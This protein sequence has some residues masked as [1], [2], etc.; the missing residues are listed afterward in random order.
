MQ[1]AHTPVEKCE[2]ARCKACIKT[3]FVPFQEFSR[4]GSLRR[5]R[6]VDPTTMDVH[7]VT[8]DE[9]VSV[10]NRSTGRKI[11]GAKAPP[12]KYLKEWLERNPG[13][14]IDPKWSHIV[15]AKVGTM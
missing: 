10:I 9:N 14:D 13:F 6:R 3:P 12:L 4:S 11:T 15:N 5:R 2:N 7:S 1:L 8:G